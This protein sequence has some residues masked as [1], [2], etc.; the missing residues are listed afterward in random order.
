M[1]VSAPRSS[2]FASGAT[3]PGKNQAVPSTGV[4]IN[5]NEADV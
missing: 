4:F 3:S 5:R 1:A 2:S